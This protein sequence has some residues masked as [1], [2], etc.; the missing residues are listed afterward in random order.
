MTTLDAHLLALETKTGKV[1]WD[2][3]LADYKLGYASTVAPLVVKGKLIVGIAGGEYANRG[4]L[5]AYEPE[6]ASASGAS[7]RSRTG[8]A[9]Q[10]DMAGRR[11]RARRRADLGDRHVRSADLNIVYWGTGNP[12]PDWDGDSRPATT[13]MRRRSSRSIP[14]RES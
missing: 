10:R 2:V 5:D 1:V 3:E 12:N 9:G 8:R 11:A 7:G 13:S 4:F 6:T 14:T